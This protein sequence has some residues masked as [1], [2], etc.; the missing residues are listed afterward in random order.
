MRA[1][2]SALRRFRQDD[3]AAVIAA[4]QELKAASINDYLERQMAEAPPLTN[5]QRAKIAELLE[6][7]RIR[8]AS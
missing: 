3:D 4:R 1:R 7:V 6:P 5:E 2:H 8:G